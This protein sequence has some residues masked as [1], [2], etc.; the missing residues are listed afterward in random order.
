MKDNTDERSKKQDDKNK[1]N[2]TEILVALI[3][4]AATILAAF[5][6]LIPNWLDRD[7]SDIHPTPEPT[8]ISQTT[9]ASTSAPTPVSISTPTPVPTSVEESVTLASMEVYKTDDSS[10]YNFYE[11]PSDTNDYISAQITGNHG[12]RFQSLI[13]IRKTCQFDFFVDEKFQLFQT[14]VCPSEDAR[15]NLN[16]Y[17]MLQG[18]NGVI[19]IKKIK[20]DGSVEQLYQSANMNGYSEAEE[21]EPFD[22]S[23]A[24]YLRIEYAVNDANAYGVLSPYVYAYPDLYIILGNPVLTPS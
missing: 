10:A 3:G 11:N 5:I 21:P 22:I 23:D 20:S 6:A 1:D 4:A 8:P 14:T 15:K 16:D 7:G 2:R 13:T 9:P 12:E 24:R 19:T 17:S 18:L